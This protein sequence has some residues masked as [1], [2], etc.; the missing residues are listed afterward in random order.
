[1]ERTNMKRL[2]AACAAAASLSTFGLAG[3]ALAE[4]TPPPER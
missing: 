4:D 2:V 1:M 3:S